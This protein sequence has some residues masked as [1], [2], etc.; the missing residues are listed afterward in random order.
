MDH[1]RRRGHSVASK[2]VGLMGLRFQEAIADETLAL[3]KVHSASNPADV[4]TTA[5]PG[6]KICELR[7]FAFVFLCHSEN[8]MGADPEIWSLSQLEVPEW[9]LCGRQCFSTAARG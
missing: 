9:E 3:E 6:D 1:S 8:T 4:C 2:H 5:L 7:R